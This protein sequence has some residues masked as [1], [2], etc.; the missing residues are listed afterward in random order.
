[1]KLYN[2]LTRKTEDFEPIEP[3]KVR[4]YTCGPTVYDYQHIGNYI[5]YVRW[6]IL[7]RTLNDQG[8]DV[9]WIMNITDVG[10]LVSDDDAGEDKLEKGARREGKTAWEVA[11]FYTEDFKENLRMLNICI[12]FDHL[13]RATDYI[14][15]QI[16]LIQTLES[17]GHTYVT[18]DGVYFDSTTFPDYGNLA[19]LD[20]EGLQAGARVDVAGKKHP[21]DFALWKFSPEGSKRDMEWESPWGKGFPGWHIECSALAI[22]FL[23]ETLDIHAGGID[24]IPVHHTNEIAQSESATGKKFANFWVHGNFLNIGGTKISKSLQNFFTIHD[25][26]E[27]GFNAEDFR[28]FVLQSHY[29]TEANFTWDNIAAARQRRLGLQAAADLRFQT[30]ENAESVQSKLKE[31]RK[32]IA[33]SLS[34]DLNT[35]E[36]LASLSALQD[37]LANGIN[38]SDKFTDFLTWL[39]EVLGLRLTASSDIREEQRTKIKEREEARSEKN[40]AVSDQIRDELLKQGIGLNDT[41]TGAIWYRT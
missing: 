12:P 20:I 28:M 36:A 14:D 10:H 6:D 40:W 34:N 22:R 35:P 2:T 29:R 33:A 19:R 1:M 17:R 11:Q 5:T 7:A 9:N 39:D 26:E 8:F 38:T 25:L 4:L 31:T 15:D 27:K 37:S 18:D 16:K 3:G 13:A 24:H 23:G 32:N 21:T 41:P 30:T